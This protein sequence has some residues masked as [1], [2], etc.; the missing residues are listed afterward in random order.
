MHSRFLRSIVLGLWLVCL[1][2]APRAQADAA[3]PPQPADP[4]AVQTSEG[5]EKTQTTPAAIEAPQS[6]GVI[7]EIIDVAVDSAYDEQDPAVALC[8]YDQYLVVYEQDGNIYGQ[9]LTN[10]GV[11]LGGAFVI[12][13]GSNAASN[14]HV[15]CDWIYQN[16]FVV[17]WEYLYSPTDPDILAQA[18]FG[19]HQSSG[20]QLD[21]GY[22]PVAETTYAETNP[23][24]ACNSDDHTCLIVFEYDDTGNGDIYGRRLSMTDL[25]LNDRFSIST[26]TADEY[27]PDVAWGGAA[28]DYLVAWQYYYTSVSPAHYRIMDAYV[29]DT[30]QTGT[31]IE[32]GV[33]ALIDYSSYQHNQTLPAVVFSR[34]AGRYLVVFQYD[35]Y[36][37]GSDHDILGL[38]LIPPLYSQGD[39]F[40]VAGTNRQEHSPAVAY[41]GGP[42]N[43]PGMGADQF[44]VTYVY[45]GSTERVLYGQPVKGAYDTGGTQLDGDPA[46][47]YSTFTGINAGLYNPDV[48][49][50]LN[51]GRYLAVWESM[52]GGFAGSDY[53]VRGRLIAPYVLYLPLVISNYAP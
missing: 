6:V 17:V 15:A 39:V 44:L 48:S 42:E 47:M 31:Q 24:I 32:E 51:N 1:A 13:D 9:R 7:G 12:F 43:L 27:N 23:A 34:D 37:D 25:T 16:R 40:Y 46:A 3:D 38:R 45:E 11:L 36:G 49:G 35:Y 18:V 53:D 26:Y 19:N 14:P 8:T 28:D 30:H 33:K 50:S 10:T 21:G 22:L 29:Y 5:A 2:A 4:P 52:L 41:S 20:G